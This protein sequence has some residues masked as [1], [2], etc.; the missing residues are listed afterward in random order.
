MKRTLALVALLAVAAVLFFVL[1][2]EE[3]GP[4]ALRGA[5][6]AAG[7]PSNANESALVAADAAKERTSVAVGAIPATAEAAVSDLAASGAPTVDASQLARIRGVV[8]QHDGTPAVGAKLTVRG[9]EAGKDRV[10]QFGRPTTPWEDVRGTTNADGSFEIAFDPPGAYQFTFEIAAAWAP[11]ATW[12][13]GEVPP[14][15]LIDLG[16]IELPLGGQIEV[17]IVRPDGSPVGGAW[18]VFTEDSLHGPLRDHHEASIYA[19]K[20][21]T[22]GRYVF[23]G[24]APGNVEITPVTSLAAPPKPQRVEVVA[25]RTAT[26]TFVFVGPPIER[27]LAFNYSGFASRMF[28]PPPREHVHV[29]DMQGVEVV[30]GTVAVDLDKSYGVG[31]V[32][33]DLEPGEYVIAVD[34]PRFAAHL[35]EPLA[36]GGLHTLALEGSVTLTLTVTSGGRPVEGASFVA[37]PLGGD[38]QRAA[39]RGRTRAT[40][41]AAPGEYVLATVPDAQ[42]WSV[43]ALGHVT[44]EVELATGLAPGSVQRAT[45]ELERGIGIGGRVLDANGEP[46]AGVEVTAFV[47]RD[48]QAEA[49][50]RTRGVFTRG[51]TPRTHAVSAAD[52]SYWIGPLDAPA[53]DLVTDHP[54]A[55]CGFALAVPAG[56]EG[57]DLVLAPHGSLTGHII[58]EFEGRA[59][60][61]IGLRHSGAPSRLP[62][63]LTLEGHHRSPVVVAS[64]GTFR[65]D[66]QPVGAHELVLSIAPSKFAMGDGSMTI[67]G[68]RL[69]SAP[70]TI[71]AG[72]TTDVVVDVSNDLPLEARFHVDETSGS[73]TKLRVV[74]LKL[75][76]HE[77]GNTTNWYIEAAADVGTDG[78]AE[79]SPITPGTWRFELRPY[80]APWGWP[81]GDEIEIDATTDLERRVVVELVRARFAVVD[82]SGARIPECHF[83]FPLEGMWSSMQADESGELELEMPPGTYTLE[84]GHEVPDA[85][86]TLRPAQPIQLVWTRDGP[87]EPVLVLR[88]ME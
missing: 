58:P 36:T 4:E 38:S 54:P 82:P 77:S 47:A 30:S 21:P 32:F 70:Y 18:T 15:R 56:S 6:T 11:M 12:R 66:F 7:E 17:D 51:N 67:G 41:G 35:S 53:H 52:G 10:Q 34:D 60:V 57:V 28:G 86:G 88:P 40:A 64:D 85:N 76:H 5:D 25:G 62:P 37:W 26:V 33:D 65:A 24:L 42:V 87:A 13:W 55:V 46:L 79:V 74:G 63:L 73:A 83:A 2:G 68:A 1:R 27:M 48:A 75:V 9:W 45:V 39:T 71:A 14:G 3:R 84:P 44:G 8:L 43:S 78:W 16:T 20:D 59:R 72:V 22:T 23:V 80:D 69:A 49:E 29:R 19:E 81:I 61:S 50:V 31:L